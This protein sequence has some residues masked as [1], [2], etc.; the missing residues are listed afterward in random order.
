[1]REDRCEA[2]Q[3]QFINGKANTAVVALLSCVFATLGMYS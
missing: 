2:V 1:M 3:G